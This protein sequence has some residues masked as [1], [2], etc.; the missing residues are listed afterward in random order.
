MAYMSILYADKVTHSYQTLYK[1]LGDSSILP[2][3]KKS[4][5]EKKAV[6][7]CFI[8]C[9]TLCECILYIRVSGNPNFAA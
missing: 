9:Y 2:R 1:K 7:I 3:N 5:V 4:A 8:V 6:E